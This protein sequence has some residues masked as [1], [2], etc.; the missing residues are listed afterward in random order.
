[1]LRRKTGFVLLSL[2]ALV[3]SACGR[4]D[5]IYGDG[6]V[7]DDGKNGITVVTTDGRAY[8]PRGLFNQS[9]NRGV[10]DVWIGSTNYPYLRMRLLDGT[11]ST[12]GFN[13]PGIG[14]RAL[15]GVSLY[16]TTLLSNFDGVK[17]DF[18]SDGL[19]PEVLLQ[20]DLECNGSVPRLLTANANSLLPG[21][22]LSGGYRRLAATPGVAAWTTNLAVTDPLDPS[23]VLLDESTPS[24]LADVIAAY[25]NACIK[26]AATFDL[27]MPK[28]L[29]TAGVLLSLGSESTTIPSTVLIDR[30]EID[31]DVINDWELP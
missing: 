28:G 30:I 23:I 22:A 29:P 14:N 11:N 26:N 4:G 8:L 31:G 27:A 17:Y 1:M 6:A 3:T 9:V 19:M 13:G 21:V 10:V 2:V 16:D 18:T 25:P 5:L 15:V 24:T 12:G 20:V 7:A